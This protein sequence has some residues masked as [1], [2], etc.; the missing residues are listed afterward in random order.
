VRP[1]WFVGM[2]LKL[3]EPREAGRVAFEMLS[4]RL[5]RPLRMAYWC[6]G[7]P[8][9]I[10]GQLTARQRKQEDSYHALGASLDW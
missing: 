5:A 10:T 7:L 2:R 9:G 1:S 4:G 6:C 8:G 3:E